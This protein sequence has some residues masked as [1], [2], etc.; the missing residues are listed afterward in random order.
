MHWLI[1]N[2]DRS[3]NELR[4]D[5]SLPSECRQGTNSF[6]IVGYGAPSPRIGTHRYMFDLY[7]L[8]IRLDHIPEGANR[9]TLERAM[10]KHVIAR[11]Q[12]TGTVTA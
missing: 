5:V 8:N 7:A 2:I 11:T 12:L 1:W 10:Q 6:G 3:V 9:A 4:A